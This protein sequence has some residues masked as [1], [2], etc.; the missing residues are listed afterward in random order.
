MKRTEQTV[1]GLATYH[2]ADFRTYAPKHVKNA[3]GRTVVIQLCETLE[4]GR[5]EP[6]YSNLTPSY[7]QH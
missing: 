7:A 5:W 4:E 1:N 2:S 3:Q 6:F